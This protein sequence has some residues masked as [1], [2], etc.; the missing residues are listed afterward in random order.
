ML[1]SRSERPH[2]STP[3]ISLIISHQSLCPDIVN[4][5]SINHLI[6]I[7]TIITTI[8]T[9]SVTTS[10]TQLIR[11]NVGQHDKDRL[12]VPLL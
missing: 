1:V 2:L 3:I 8:I 7:L 4:Q 9:T 10:F 11:L 5:E 6:S 12:G